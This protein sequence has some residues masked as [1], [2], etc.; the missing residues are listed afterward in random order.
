MRGQDRYSCTGH[1]TG[2]CTNRRSI[3][4]TVLEDRVLTGLKHGLMA[5]GR[6]RHARF[7]IVG[8]G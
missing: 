8:L 7:G 5:P 4:R 1:V 6:D 3:R 2:G